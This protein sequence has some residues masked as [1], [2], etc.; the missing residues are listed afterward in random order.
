MMHV[1]RKLLAHN[2]KED[3]NL[4]VKEWKNA[5]IGYV[6]GGN[7]SEAQ[8]AEFI[9][10]VWGFVGLPKI[11]YHEYKDG[12]YVFKF[13]NTIDKEKSDANRSLSKLASAIGIP[14]YI[15]GF[16]ENVEKISYARV[17]IVMDLAKRLS[18][19]IVVETPSGPWDR[20]TDTEG[21]QTGDPC[22]PIPGYASCDNR[23]SRTP[24]DDLNG[25]D[26][27]LCVVNQL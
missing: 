16:T 11:L 4:R 12:Y 6:I 7:S 23:R 18:D 17:L 21:T 8:M 26:V 24:I 10:K 2:R 19:V 1:K 9:R 25:Q 5:L 22:S 15:H 14:L 20:Y 3:I 13:Q 27:V